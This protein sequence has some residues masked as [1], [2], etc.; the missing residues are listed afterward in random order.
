MVAG[1]EAPEWAS[2]T[3]SET[4]NN[5]EVNVS[6]YSFQPMVRSARAGHRWE[7]ES[8]EDQEVTQE[9]RQ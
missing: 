1:Q 9:E 7:V 5:F 4:Q 2:T 8:G 6:V 3:E